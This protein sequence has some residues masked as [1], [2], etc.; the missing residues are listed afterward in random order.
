V[1]PAA[2][3]QSL[4]CSSPEAVQ[5]TG[6]VALDQRRWGN[7][8]AGALSPFFVNLRSVNRFLSTLSVHVSLFQ[9][10]RAFEVNIVDLI[11]IETVRVFEPGVYRRIASSKGLLTSGVQSVKGA[12]NS[13]EVQ[14]I[15]DA[16]TE[17]HRDYVRELL[18]QL[19]PP[20]ESAFGGPH[21][22]SEFNQSWRDELR[23][24]SAAVFDR[25]FQM[26]IPEGDL[27]E[28]EF[29][30]MLD[31]TGEREL[32]LGKFEEIRARGLLDVMLSRLDGYAPKLDLAN[33]LA[34]VASLMDVGEDLPDSS[35]FGLGADIHVLRIIVRYLGQEPTVRNFS[36]GFTE[37]WWDRGIRSRNLQRG[38]VS[39]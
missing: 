11:G 24:C 25:Y 32:F 15:I 29:R 37:F 8:F 4:A 1:K 23:V 7:L 33:A 38:R 3:Y 5:T 22:A 21:Y 10:A 26:G 12:A 20:I 28:S 14:A 34:F 17:E 2:G 13:G 30:Q 39:L 36:R 9:S 6:T 27:S 31:L 16:A 18:K 35:G 19:F